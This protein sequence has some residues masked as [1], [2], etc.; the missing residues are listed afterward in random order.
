MHAKLQVGAWAILGRVSHALEYLVLFA[1]V[2][3]ESAG[4]FV[5]GETALIAAA[6]LAARGR[7]DLPVVIAVAAAGAI[8]GDNI[9]YVAGRRG[10]RRLLRRRQRLVEQAER[11]FERH[12]A[13]AVFLARWITGLRVVA[14]WVAGTSAMP[15][16]RFVLWNALGGIAWAISVGA[17]GYVLGRAAARVLGA[18]GVGL[19]IAVV[20][21]G[22]ALLAW[23]RRAS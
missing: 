14:A 2:G 1:L 11:F 18:L 8:V 10:V 15:W 16:R 12:G 6:A 22:L 9:G 5:P 19:A 20:A 7:L 4:L 23:R 21:A 13:P 3:G 17:L